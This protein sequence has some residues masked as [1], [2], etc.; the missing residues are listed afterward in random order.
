MRS[1]IEIFA[2]AMEEVLKKND[3]KGGWKDCSIEYLFNGIKRNVSNLKY[4]FE[5]STLKRI[6]DCENIKILI[7]DIQKEIIDIANYCMMIHK[8]LE[9]KISL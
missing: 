1:S 3:F 2:G 5:I 9:E 7:K 8:N 4:T 6:D